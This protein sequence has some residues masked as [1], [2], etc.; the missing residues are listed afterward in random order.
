[1]RG[2]KARRRLRAD[3]WPAMVSQF[4]GSG[5]SAEASSHQQ[6]VSLASLKHWQEK[7]RGT[8]PSKRRLVDC[9]A[10]LTLPA[11]L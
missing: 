1:M 5:M 11:A 3:G 8:K 7:L 9:V 6:R 10:Q 2:A 4:V